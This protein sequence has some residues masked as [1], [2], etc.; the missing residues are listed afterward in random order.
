MPRTAVRPYLIVK[1]EEG[2]FRITVRTTRFNSQ[3]YPLVTANLLEGGFPTLTTARAYVR[4]QFRAE[5]T[6]IATK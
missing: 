1:D 4:Q 5:A 6:D 2:L 3:G